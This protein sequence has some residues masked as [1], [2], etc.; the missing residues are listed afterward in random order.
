[1]RAVSQ[2]SVVVPIMNHEGESYG[3]QTSMARRYQHGACRY[4]W[5][6]DIFNDNDP[7]LREVLSDLLSTLSR[8]AGFPV[9]A[10]AGSQVCAGLDW[11]MLVAP[12]IAGV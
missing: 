11:P 1:M 12:L 8:Q 5:K 3:V 9:S 10:Q 6:D 2:V 4:E 7:H